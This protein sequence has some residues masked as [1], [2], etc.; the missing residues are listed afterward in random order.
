MYFE[1]SSTSST[2]VPFSALH[3]IL[4]IYHTAISHVFLFTT[5]SLGYAKLSTPLVVSDFPQCL[6]SRVPS[7]YPVLPLHNNCILRNRFRMTPHS[8]WR[9]LLHQSCRTQSIHVCIST[10]TSLTWVPSTVIYYI[11]YTVS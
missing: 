9:I 1:P 6:D 5:Q 4:C 8:L 2:C 10:L 7:S 3:S 11:P